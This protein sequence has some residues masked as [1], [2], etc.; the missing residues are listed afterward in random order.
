MGSRKE[1]VVNREEAHS[2]RMWT[3]MQQ[4]RSRTVSQDESSDVGRREKA[5]HWQNTERNE[6]NYESAIIL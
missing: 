6:Q 1:S 4:E 5:E 2:K 3:Q